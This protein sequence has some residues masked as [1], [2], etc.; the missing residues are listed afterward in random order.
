[1]SRSQGKC[2]EVEEGRHANGEFRFPII[3]VVATK[4][5]LLLFATT[6][7]N[8]NLSPSASGTPPKIFTNEIS[9]PPLSDSPK[10]TLLRFSG[11]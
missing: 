1:M 10:Y 2:L 7:F 8:F 6:I 11:A 9:C 4:F 5:T 3:V